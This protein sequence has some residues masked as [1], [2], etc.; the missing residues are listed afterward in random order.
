[1]PNA[2]GIVIV[3]I[4]SILKKWVDELVPATSDL[5]K[6]YD[7]LSDGSDVHFNQLNIWK[8]LFYIEG[9]EGPG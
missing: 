5:K 1:M 2:S 3:D 7:T 8:I 9:M 4:V 6:N